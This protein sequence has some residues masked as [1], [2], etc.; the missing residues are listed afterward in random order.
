MDKKRFHNKTNIDIHMKLGY[1][2]WTVC[3]TSASRVEDVITIACSPSV[4]RC[5]LRV[6]SCAQSVDPNHLEQVFS[7]QPATAVLT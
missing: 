7:N 5:D 3:V 6:I 2:E 1:S 4:T